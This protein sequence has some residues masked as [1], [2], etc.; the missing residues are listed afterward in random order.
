MCVEGDQNEVSFVKLGLHPHWFELQLIRFQPELETHVYWECRLSNYDNE[1]VY[2]LVASESADLDW[3]IVMAAKNNSRSES[4][5]KI[6]CRA[7][8]RESDQKR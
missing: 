4:N 2:K 7:Q 8:I 6:K 5:K 1:H 3:P